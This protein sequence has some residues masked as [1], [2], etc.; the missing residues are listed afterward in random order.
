MDNMY[1]IS[2]NIYFTYQQIKLNKITK[3]KYSNRT[4]Q[5]K[6][7]SINKSINQKMQIKEASMD[8]LMTL[9]LDEKKENNKGLINIYV[10]RCRKKKYW[11]TS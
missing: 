8:N 2:I 10:N 5:V 6:W 3:C 9:S 4:S 1:L 11:Y 7:R